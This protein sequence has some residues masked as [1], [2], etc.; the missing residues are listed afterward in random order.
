LLYTGWRAQEAPYLYANGSGY[1][2]DV[3][4]RVSE[5]FQADREALDAQIAFDVVPVRTWQRLLARA[6]T[7]RWVSSCSNLF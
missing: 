7:S 5:S 6:R 1:L 4:R 2:S 3:M